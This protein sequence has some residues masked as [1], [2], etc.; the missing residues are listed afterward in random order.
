MIKGIKVKKI[1][2]LNWRDIK[3]PSSGGAEIL[4]HEIAK[5]FVMWGHQ[6]TQFSS[7]FPNCLAE[8]KVDGVK[9]I[10]MGHPDARFLFSSVHF[11]AF[12]YYRKN[13]GKFDVVV[14]EIHGLPFFTPWYVKEKKV[15]LIC[16]VA[17]EL[18]TNMFGP[19][20]GTLG[21]IVEWYYLHF[22]Y[23][24][25]HFLTISESSKD[26]LIKEGIKEKNITIL[27]M[28]L[29][30]PNNLKTYEKEKTPTLIFVG[31]L[32]RQ[33]GIEDA[34]I[35]LK[36]VSKK[37]PKIKLWIVGRGEKNYVSYLK[38]LI[39][40]IKIEKQVIFFGFVE[41]Y[42]KFE[43]MQR[44][45][46]LLVPSIKEGWGLTVPEAA[47]VGTPSIV[48]N[49][50]GLRDVLRDSPFKIIVRS[51]TPTDLSKEVLVLLQK[52][53]FYKILTRQKTTVVEQFN[54]NKTAAVALNILENK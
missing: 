22:A 16:E 34:I 35:V 20:F 19:I 27:P 52:K 51:N 21:R 37:I 29:S 36:K 4:T 11:L 48:Y 2:I 18:W 49:S 15:V 54:W 24:N 25:I 26:D 40:K 23:S 31:R 39:K 28:G 53:N 45:H 8:E 17:N 47:A 50:Q 46:V 13:V 10:R 38:S 7:C 44:A 12:K 42:K 32:S 14:D 3:N 5:R 9:I 41:E 6:V 1:L 43:F 33:K 30:I